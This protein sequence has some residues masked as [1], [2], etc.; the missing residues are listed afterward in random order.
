MNNST[1]K[2][3]YEVAADNFM[4]VPTTPIAYW[5]SERFV[6]C[7]SNK[8]IDEYAD[9]NNGFTTGDNN[10]FLRIWHEVSQT[11]IFYN[12]ES[13]S[14]AK[15]SGK[16]WF[17]YNKGG[18]ARKW[19][20]NNDY[21][22]NWFNDGADIKEYG[23]LVARSQKYMFRASITW[24]KISSSGCSFR[25]KSKGNMFDVAGLSLFTYN[26]ENQMYLLGLCNTVFTQKCLDVLSP[27]LNCETGHV[28]SIP[29]IIE[30]KDEVDRTVKENIEISKEDWDSF[31]TSWD[32]KKHP[33]I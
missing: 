10:R 11:N 23:H 21:L 9:T 27:T 33:L 28:A 31:E 3:R 15:L 5:M 1:Q 12:A 7:F 26:E 4:K 8:K 20:G 18:E 30:R 16:R 24:S 6:D 29:V 19:Y 14:S 25:Y 13:F 22:I 17:P 32:F 2:I